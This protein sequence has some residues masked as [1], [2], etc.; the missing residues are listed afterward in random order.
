MYQGYSTIN[1]DWESGSSELICIEMSW[2]CSTF[3]NSFTT[4]LQ[5]CENNTRE[6]GNHNFSSKILQQQQLVK[7]CC[8]TPAETNQWTLENRNIARAISWSISFYNTD[9]LTTILPTVIASI[10]VDDLDFSDIA[11][12]LMV[13]V[14]LGS[15]NELV[16][17]HLHMQILNS[18]IF[19]THPSLSHLS[20]RQ[21]TGRVYL[22]IATHCDYL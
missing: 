17:C 13:R 3:E 1:V 18:Q 15:R 9:V 21:A 7:H 4:K 5:L 11:W 10:C 6:S 22:N 20:G 8:I 19:I 16:N 14:L 12:A 2:G